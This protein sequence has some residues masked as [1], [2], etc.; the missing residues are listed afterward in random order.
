MK[1]TEYVQET[2]A[3]KVFTSI[4]KAKKRESDT[5]TQTEKQTTPKTDRGKDGKL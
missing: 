4:A 1:K 5:H 2:W 3:L